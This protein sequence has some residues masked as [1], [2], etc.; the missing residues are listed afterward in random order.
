MLLGWFFALFALW[1]GFGFFKL[2][3]IPIS[4]AVFPIILFSWGAHFLGTLFYS[5]ALSDSSGYY[6][7]LA[8]SGV[9]SIFGDTGSGH[10]LNLVWYVRDFFTGDSYVATLM[11]FGM[12]A[13]WGSILWYCFFL[14]LAQRLQI[15]TAFFT[16]VPAFIL[17]CWPSFL[18]FTAGIK[19]AWIFFFI[20]WSLLSTL[21]ME[22]FSCKLGLD[23][24][25]LL[26]AAYMVF[27]VRPYL[28]LIFG[29][30]FYLS[31]IFNKKWHLLM[32]IL[33]ACF[34]LGGLF[35]AVKY[36]FVSASHMSS[37]LHGIHLSFDSIATH[38]VVQQQLLSVGSS[39]PMPSN[40][41]LV[42]LL[43]PYSFLMNLCFPLFIFAN[44]ALSL[45]V[46]C[47]NLFLLYLIFFFLKHRTIFYEYAKQRIM[48]VFLFY[49]F[50]VGIAFTALIN[51]N[52][53]VAI[54]NKTMYLPAFLVL[55]CI[56][57]ARLNKDKQ[58]RERVCVK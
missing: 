56:I 8:T 6:F 13:F 36:I 29:G 38:A 9:S 39:F 53:G 50:V 15:D 14:K 7:P 37:A 22:F 4:K 21:E 16:K 1:I 47:E 20:A 30:G 40:P 49:Y 10:I 26:F 19:D 34:F 54:R 51:T 12:F 46:S 3:S 17:L 11:F 25:F 52:F 27:F 48:V 45:L 31:V 33:G 24:L 5:F 23:F 28:I 18:Y 2:Y 57:Y 55:V 58:M 42:F 44:S 35:F 32:R 43:W 41:S